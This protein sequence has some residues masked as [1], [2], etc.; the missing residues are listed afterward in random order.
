MGA[1]APIRFPPVLLRGGAARRGR[2]LHGAA[3]SPSI[4]PSDAA[5]GL[6]RGCGAK[7]A[8]K[9]TSLLVAPAEYRRQIAITLWRIRT[10][11]TTRGSKTSSHRN[12]KVNVTVHHHFPPALC[13]RRSILDRRSLPP[14]RQRHPG[15]HPL[16][17]PPSVGRPHL[18]VGPPLLGSD[19][20][21][22][23]VNYW[24]SVQ[25]MLSSLWGMCR[26]RR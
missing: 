19:V 20:I 6:R 25:V 23:Q 11:S 10:T 18:A 2:G 24:M 22:R 1:A 26:C 16:P 4:R 13:H 8:S 9:M 7:G 5:N 12:A 3:T 14:E 17:H 21:A 15:V